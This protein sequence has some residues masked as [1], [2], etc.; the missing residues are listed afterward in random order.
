MPF[1]STRISVFLLLLGI[2]IGACAEQQTPPAAK[3]AKPERKPKMDIQLKLKQA[4]YVIGEE[5]E[6]QVTLT[7]N[8]NAP[9]AVPHPG[10]MRN[11]EPSYKLTGPSYPEGAAFSKRSSM[12]GG[13]QQ[14][15][16]E[17]QAELITL[18]PG[19][20]VTAELYLEKM[21]TLNTAGEY[22]IAAHIKW[23]GQSAQ[24]LPLTF[25]LDLMKARW[26]SVG[27]DTGTARVSDVWAAW[28]HP[29]EGTQRLYEG[30][31]TEIRPDL[32]EF[33][34]HTAVPVAPLP[35]SAEQVLLP[36]TNFSRQGLMFWWR[37]WREG[38]H[39]SALATRAA[40]PERLDIGE[41]AHHLIRPALMSGSRDLDVFAFAPKSSELILARFPAPPPFPQT[42]EG[43]PPHILW[44]LPLPHPPLMG[45]CAL[46]PVSRQSERH[47]VIVAQDGEFLLIQHCNAGDGTKPGPLETA[48]LRNAF[49]IPGVE[50]GI[51]T[52][53]QG[54]THLAV[55]YAT[56]AARRHISIVDIVIGADGKAQKP[57][58]TRLTVLPDAPVAGAICYQLAANAPMRRDWAILMKNGEVAHSVAPGH[59]QRLDAAPTVPLEL[60]ALSKASYLLTSDPKKGPDFALLR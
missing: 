10:D 60:L 4:H 51:E 12:R 40:K 47:I 43:A 7:N 11:W 31:Y 24:A 50:P 33:R 9:F 52:D 46:A 26:L 57:E 5:I 2:C 39:L 16:P 28:L 34:Q 49:P 38:T 35:E 53:A 48:R 58:F 29:G 56:D 19:E 1:V 44:R 21:V 3:G 14:T 22:H 20:S 55:L 13:P 32:G 36:W 37:A 15:F 6:L 25:H 41:A 54:V 8:T 23:K 17:D 18:A 27:V 30:M 42:G 45:R 59:P